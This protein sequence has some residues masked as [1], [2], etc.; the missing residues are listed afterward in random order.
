MSWAES[1]TFLAACFC[2]I[3]THGSLKRTG[4]GAEPGPVQISYVASVLSWATLGSLEWQHTAT[5]VLPCLSS[6]LLPAS[7]SPV[8]APSVSGVLSL[9]SYYFLGNISQLCKMESQLVRSHTLNR[10]QTQSSLLFS[11]KSE[12]YWAQ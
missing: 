11:N 5:R 7:L 12:Q 1:P 2:K 3:G 9:L 6:P 8:P 10:Q 4:Q